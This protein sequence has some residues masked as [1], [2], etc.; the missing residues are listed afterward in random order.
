MGR[1][2]DGRVSSHLWTEISGQNPLYERMVPRAS[3]DPLRKPLR[4]AAANT[5]YGPDHT[6]LKAVSAKIQPV[7]ARDESARK[8]V[9]LLNV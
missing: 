7:S 3:S 9:G 6:A 5:D 8:V 4:P 2:Q 1:E